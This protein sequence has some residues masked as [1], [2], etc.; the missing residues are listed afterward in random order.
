MRQAVRRGS[1]ALVGVLTLVGLAASLTYFAREPANRGFLDHPVIVAAHVVFGAIYLTLAPWQFVARI[2]SRHPAYH[3]RAG[4]LLVGVGLAVGMTALFMG[5]VIPYAGW[6]EAV[7]IAVFGS[8]FIVSLGVGCWHI[9]A[10]RVSQHREWMMRAFTIG[11]AIATQRVIFLPALLIAG[12]P[13]YEQVVTLSLAAWGTALVLHTLAAE[14]WIRASRSR[15]SSR[16]TVLGT[17]RTVVRA[18]SRATQGPA[19]SG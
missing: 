16:R 11:L 12:D 6:P 13:S 5:L 4:R 17:D 7:L 3:R 2:R 19:S 15:P 1:G 9:R 8:L 18:G 14:V 10:R